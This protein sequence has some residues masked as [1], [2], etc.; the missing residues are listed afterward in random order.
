MR[1]VYKKEGTFN[2]IQGV[3]G[4]SH[5][6]QGIKGEQCSTQGEVMTVKGPIAVGAYGT[7]KSLWLYEKN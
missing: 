1:M 6:G 5:D 3:Q 4:V 2:L 7:L